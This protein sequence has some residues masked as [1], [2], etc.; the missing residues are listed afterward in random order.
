VR[1]LSHLLAA[2]AASLALLA[3]T[4]A[5]A[6]TGYFA[7][8]Y[9]TIHKGLA[10]AGVAKP[11][12]SLAQAMNPAGLVNIGNQWDLG[13]ALFSP[14][15]KYTVS[16]NPSFQPGTFP[17]GQGK[18][19]SDSN[20]FLLPSFG[21]ASEIDEE[22]SWGVAVY[23]NG[24]MNTDYSS[25]ASCALAGAPGTGIPPGQGGTFC[26]GETG[27]DL[28]QL[29]ISPTYSRR[30]NEKFSWGVTPIV[31]MQW[32]EAKGLGRFGQFGFSS[33]P[34]KLTNNGHDFSYGMGVRLGLQGEVVDGLHLGL[35]YQSKIWMTKFDDYKGLFAN[36]GSF[37]IP[38]TL[39][40]GLA[41]DVDDSK[42]LFF[43]WQRIW[44]SDEDSIHN[45]LNTSSLMQG[46]MTGNNDLLL[47]GNKGPGFGWQN[48]NVYK[49]GFQWQSSPA[50]TWRA[51]YS[52]NDQPIPKSQVLFNILAPGVVKQHFTFG[53]T[54]TL[55]DDSG[56]D[57]SFMYAPSESVKG[58]NAFDPSQNVELE[59]KQYELSLNYSKRF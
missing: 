25:N 41:W 54:R 9:S 6:T 11:Q 50:W 32:F 1:K 5:Q 57:F 13:A 42:T 58:P 46:A 7:N 35:A 38:S 31:A 40:L 51:G 17:L 47:G 56:I 48:I 39:S 18:E 16:G 29:F 15:R 20:Y 28:M 36:Q 37:D 34:D 49:L 19:D 30:I 45:K 55:S 52:Y 3:G 2:G 26:D 22:S 12:D 27:V 44:Y 53:F 10:G 23:G 4:G 14:R 33:N 59:M 21:Y 24:G 43:D 8:G